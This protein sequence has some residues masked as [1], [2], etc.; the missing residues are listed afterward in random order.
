MSFLRIVFHVGNAYFLNQAFSRN[1]YQIP[2]DSKCHM[3]SSGLLQFSRMQKTTSLTFF[4]L[5]S[6]F[7]SSGFNCHKTILP[8]FEI[9]GNVCKDLPSSNAKFPKDS[10]DLIL[11]LSTRIRRFWKHGARRNNKHSP[12]SC[13]NF[14]S[15]ATKLCSMSLSG[16]SF[17][18]DIS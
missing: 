17:P 10:A 18:R 1:K 4:T 15:R 8:R 5:F 14:P 7:I 13:H 2:L 9:E 12:F 3:D 16:L 11:S 6:Y